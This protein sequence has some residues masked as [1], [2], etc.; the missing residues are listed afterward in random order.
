MAFGDGDNDV[1][2]FE[3]A[4]CSVAMPQGWPLAR[5]RAKLIA[6][7]GPAE[8]ALARGIDLVL[9]ADVATT[10]CASQKNVKA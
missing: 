2:M 7:D 4:G 8:T 1:P 10:P 5:A 9:K 3:W 6:P